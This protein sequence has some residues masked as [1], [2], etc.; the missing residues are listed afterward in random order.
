ML[1]LIEYRELA[2]SDG[3]AVRTLLA[4]MSLPDPEGFQFLGLPL[5]GPLG[6]NGYATAA[7]VKSG[8]LV[9]VGRLWTNRYHPYCR[10][11]GLYVDPEHRR[12]GIGAGL[13]RHLLASSSADSVPVQTSVWE[14]N[15]SGTRF[16]T[17]C[18]FR[19]VRRT[20][21]P[22]LLLDALSPAVL[23]KWIDAAAASGYMLLPIREAARTRAE[24]ARLGALCRDIY[25]ASHTVNPPAAL[26]DT[27][28]LDLAM[29]DDVID[30]GSFVAVRAGTF[31]GVA[32][33]H[34]EPGEGN[35]TFGLC[36]VPAELGRQAHEILVKAL[37]ARQIEA[38]RHLGIRS[39]CAELDSTDPAAMTRLATVPFSPAPAWLTFRRDVE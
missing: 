12:Q 5:K 17:T 27:E 36:G 1:A 30:D 28:W 8:R 31:V 39:M 25:T 14:T 16:L 10:Y 22:Q 33:L 13:L 23:S 2:D 29:D 34:R 3:E 21:E 18:G 35:A 6:D 11:F 38:A 4:P 20:W 15:V 9:G 26:R 19:E 24:W 7:A 37:T 32:L